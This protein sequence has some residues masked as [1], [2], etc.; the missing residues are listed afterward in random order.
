MSH[1]QQHYYEGGGHGT[2]SAQ[3]EVEAMLNSLVGPQPHTSH[4]GVYN[5]PDYNNVGIVYTRRKSRLLTGLLCRA[6]TST[7]ISSSS[8]STMATLALLHNS[9]LV[10]KVTAI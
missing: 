2:P 7:T 8:S 3:D 9:P 4:S 6:T 10:M 1:Q 5:N